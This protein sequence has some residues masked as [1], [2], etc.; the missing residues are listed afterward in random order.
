MWLD[1]FVKFFF[2]SRRRHT[3]CA[4]VTGV[5]TCALPLSHYAHFTSPIRRYAAL[6]VHRALI[7]GLKLGEDGLPPGAEHLFEEMGGHISA[8]ERSSAAAER[9]AVDRFTAA[10][11][12]ERVGARFHGRI[13]GVTQI[14]RAHV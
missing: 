4:L 9:D 1:I 13:N 12:Q 3:R 5:Q 6:L 14:G 2:S 11:L 8:T 7:S 10:F